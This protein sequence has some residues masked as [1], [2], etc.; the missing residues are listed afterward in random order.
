V[1]K[2]GVVYVGTRGEISGSNGVLGAGHAV[3]LEAATGRV[4]WKT[5]IPAPEEPAKGGVVG[6]GALTPDLYVVASVNERVYGLDRQTGQVRWTTK[7]SGVYEATGVVVLGDV[8]ISASLAGYI[9]GFDL[10]TGRPL[11]QLGPYSS[12]GSLM[13][14][15]GD[16]ALVVS[17]TLRA[18]DASGKEV[19]THNPVDSNGRGTPYSTGASEHGGVIY[20]GA[21]DA[22]YA[23]RRSR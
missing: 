16:Q 15:S 4:L 11:W 10:R 20:A 5:A 17:G 18:V 14:K 21:Y 9:D 19:W 12:I 8:A 22:F 23:L 7:G 2:D 6:A 1:Q 13:A 3:A